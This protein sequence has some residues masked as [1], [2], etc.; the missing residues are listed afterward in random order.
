MDVWGT[1]CCLVSFLSLED[2]ETLQ[3]ISTRTHAFDSQS[4]QLSL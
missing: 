1:C 4:E 3:L 2:W